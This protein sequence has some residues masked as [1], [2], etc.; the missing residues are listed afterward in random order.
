MNIGETQALLRQAVEYGCEY[1]GSLDERP[2]FPD[3]VALAALEG[4]D[5]P[6]PGQPTPPGD[7]LRELQR[8]GSSA[9]TATAGGR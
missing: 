9:T 3:A 1:L 2:V 4:F 7:V 8:L 5:E 6:L